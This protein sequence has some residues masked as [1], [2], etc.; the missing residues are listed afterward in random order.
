MKAIHMGMEVDIAEN[1]GS[2]RHP[3]ITHIDGDILNN[4]PG[5]LAV[6]DMSKDQIQLKVQTTSPWKAAMV[7]SLVGY[8]EANGWHNLRCLGDEHERV[9]LAERNKK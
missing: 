8:L 7:L 1:S 6:V 9:F 4:D 2:K 3:A 5:N